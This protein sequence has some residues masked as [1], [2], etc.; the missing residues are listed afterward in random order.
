MGDHKIKVHSKI[1][2]LSSFHMVFIA[3]DNFKIK[4]IHFRD[5]SRPLEHPD[6]HGSLRNL[7]E[8]WP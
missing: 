8:M 6:L 2:G 4:N 7:L 5:L 3:V 1:G